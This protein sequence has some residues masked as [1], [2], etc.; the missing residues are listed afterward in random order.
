M[1]HLPTRS[2]LA[3]LFAGLLAFAAPAQCAPAWLP[4]DPLAQVR[5]QLTAMAQWDPDGAGPTPL[6]LVV[7]G[8]LDVGQT[9]GQKLATWDG[10]Q[11]TPRATPTGGI[12]AMVVW[13]GQLV[14]AAS[15]A[16]YGYDGSTWTYFG[17]LGSGGNPGIVRAFSLYNGALVATGTFDTI[18]PGSATPIAASNVARFD[19]SNWS[20][21]GVGVPGEARCAAVFNGSLHVGGNLYP[22]ST[23]AAQLQAWNGSAWSPLGLWNGP[24]DTLAVRNG[25]TITNSFLFAGGSFTVI[26][27]ITSAPLVARFSPSTNSWAAIGA[28]GAG[29]APVRCSHLFVR[30]IGISNYEVTA[31]LEIPTSQKAWRLSGTTWT[32]LGSVDDLNGGVRTSSLTYFAGQYLMG[33]LPA[34]SGT[35]DACVRRYDTTTAYWPPLFGR[36]L[37]GRVYAVCGDGGDSVIGGAFVAISGVV[38][39]GIA[40]GQADAWQPLGGGLTG[41]FGVF[42]LAK[43]PNGDLIAGGDFTTAGGLPASS[44]ARWNG[45]AWAPLGAGIGGTVY[46]LSPQP[47]GDLIAAGNFTTAGG[48][49]A[50]HVARWNGATWAPLGAGTGSRIYALARLPGGDLVAAGAFTTAGGAAANRIARWN[51][52]TWAPLG[53]GLDQIAYALAIAPTGDIWVGGSFLT[54]GG[55][56]ARYAARWNGSAWQATGAGSIAEPDQPIFALAMLPNGDLVAGGPEFHWGISIPP[57]GGT[58][59]TC[60]ARLHGSS[61]ST[62][63]VSGQ[64]VQ[65]LGLRADGTLLVGGDFQSVAGNV[66]VH[67]G[68]LAPTCPA[69]AVAYGNGCNGSAGLNTLTATS[70]PWDSSTFRSRATGLPAQSAVVVAFGFTPISVPVVQLLP[71]GLP[72]CYLLTSLEFTAFG[73]PTGGVFDT[74]VFFAPS[75]SLIGVTLYHQIGAAEVSG[76]QVV[77]IS[78]TNGLALTVGSY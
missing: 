63:Q 39:N 74:E 68:A 73:V 5:G 15:G 76:S 4:G 9:T 46:A 30:S 6:Q 65:A 53:S 75:P 72:G 36:G 41:G 57:F 12:T 70:L 59:H 60:L 27:G 19:G 13:N 22:G 11:W 33:L 37:D 54:A 35:V 21:L 17:A 47:D 29:N 55:A 42:A 62:L 16:V 56:P 67:F 10:S 48:A 2:L 44:I 38:M 25:T 34:T 23:S 69:S 28:P 50:N 8:G 32:A 58:V 45:S 26:N 78:T 24:V 52:S 43:M 18:N 77:A 51:G 66:S 14:A 64:A 20:A 3:P 7:A 61:W 31:A 71:E 1:S 49:P 40:R